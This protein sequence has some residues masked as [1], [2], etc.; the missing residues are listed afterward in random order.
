MKSQILADNFRLGK[1]VPS[2]HENKDFCPLYSVWMPLLCR[3][4][5][6]ALTQTS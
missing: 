5:P 6:S 4:F 3:M 2:R 1:C